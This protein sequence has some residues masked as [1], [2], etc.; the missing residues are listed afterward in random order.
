MHDSEDNEELILSHLPLVRSI[1]KRL[2]RRYCLDIDLEELISYGLMGLVEAAERFDPNKG[3]RFSSFAYQRVRGAIL[4]G[5]GELGP[6]PRTRSRARQ[7]MRCDRDVAHLADASD[8]LDMRLIHAELVDSLALAVARLP[9]RSRMMIRQRYWRE[10]TLVSIGQELG[11][12]K[13]RASR[14][15]SAALRQ[16]REQLDAQAA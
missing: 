12:T 7:P 16:L 1:A 6:M 8:G 5:L 4:D 14:V 2:Q 15:H 10:R 13:S 3:F 9:E 11:I